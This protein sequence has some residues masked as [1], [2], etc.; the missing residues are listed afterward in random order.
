MLFSFVKGLRADNLLL[1]ASSCHYVP[2]FKSGR[3]ILGDFKLET[4]VLSSLYDH[5][6]DRHLSLAHLVLKHVSLAVKEAIMW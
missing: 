6:Q 5:K 1:C 3:C 4:R 2:F